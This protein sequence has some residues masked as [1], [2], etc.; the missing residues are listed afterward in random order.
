MRRAAFLLL[1]FLTVQSC[2][3]I[4]RI[5]N[6]LTVSAELPEVVNGNNFTFPIKIGNMVNKTRAVE[7]YS[8]VYLGSKSVSGAWTSNL[9][10]IELEPLGNKSLNLS[11]YLERVNGIYSIKVRVREGEKDLDLKSYVNIN[12]TLKNHELTGYSVMKPV[13]YGALSLFGLAALYLVMRKL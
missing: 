13:A 2:F 9:K 11:N 3:S 4:S 1:T 5:G 8:Y 6:N 12:Q 7:V 10:I